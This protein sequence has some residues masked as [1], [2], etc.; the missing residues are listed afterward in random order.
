MNAAVDGG[1]WP[2]ARSVNAASAA[3]S[4]GSS[5]IW[6]WRQGQHQWPVVFPCVRYDPMSPAGLGQFRPRRRRLG[7][8]ALM[9]S[10][11]HIAEIQRWAPRTVQRHVDIERH[12]AGFLD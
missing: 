10:T 7:T 8:R 6:Q 9:D 4:I 5:V 2:A 11:D 3:R 1:I 12:F